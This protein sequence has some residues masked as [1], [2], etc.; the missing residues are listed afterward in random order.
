MKKSTVNFSYTAKP[1]KTLVLSFVFLHALAVASLILISI[2]IWL[3]CLSILLIVLMAFNVLRRYALFISNDSIRHLSCASNK[4]CRI[5]LYNGNVH[6]V[7][8][9]SSAWLFNYFAV[10][11]LQSSSRKFKLA[12][13]KD[14]LSQ[15]QFYALRLY[16]RSKNNE[17]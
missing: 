14:T 17:R 6:Q 16:L 15:E 4:K 10:M 3:K 5:E 12:I 2:P 13:S 8:L 9:V 7:K 11:V 1:S